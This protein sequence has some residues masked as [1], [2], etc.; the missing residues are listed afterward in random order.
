M[1]KIILA[2]NTDWFL[3]NFRLELAKSLREGGFDVHLLSPGGEYVPDF[4]NQGFRWIEWHVSRR[5]ISPLSELPSIRKLAKVYR[6]EEPDL[7]HHHTIKPVKGNGKNPMILIILTEGHTGCFPWSFTILKI[8]FL[9][10]Q[11]FT[12][13]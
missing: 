4:K 2:A 3:Y 1:T 12:G 6:Q 7:V 11:N 13:N 9:R 5:G 8:I 10:N